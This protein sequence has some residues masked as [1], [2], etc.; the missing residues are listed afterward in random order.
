[1]ARRLP[2]LSRE[3]DRVWR[4]LR[5]RSR[6]GF[7]HADRLTLALAGLTATAA[8]GVLAGEFLRRFHRRAV[9]ATGGPAIVEGTVETLQ[10]AGR[11]GRDTVR[12]AVEGYGSASRHELVLFNLLTGFAG[13]FV[14]ARLSTSGIRSGWWP[15]GNVR[16]GGRHI[17]HF[18]P[19]ILLAFGSATAALLTDDLERETALAIPFGAGVGLTFD[20]AALLLDLRDV[21]WTREGLL[22]IQLSL[23]GLA[24]L[25]GTILALRMLRRGERRGERAGLIPDA[26]G[27]LVA[28]PEPESEPARRGQLRIA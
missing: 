10:V 20:E 16:I 1:M 11:A 21:Y 26:H 24:L 27:E 17:H 4:R 15:A 6:V 23:G 25:S 7:R 5:A 2:A 13:S 3:P 18:V 8:G 28:H 22:S 14:V 9:T 12:V 19:G